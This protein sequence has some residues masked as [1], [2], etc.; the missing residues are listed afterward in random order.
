MNEKLADSLVNLKQEIE[1][2]EEM[3]KLRILDKELNEDET[4]MKLA[5]KKDMLAIQY[6][7]AIKHFG[8]NS[9]EANLAQKEL[10]QAK[11]ELDN[12][13]TV[14]RYMEQYKI[15]RKMYDKINEELFNPFN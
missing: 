5:Y 8:E 6:E 1:N 15:V 10:Y 13:E 14:K 9:K 7:D 2:S 4:A 12:N 11:L 3:K